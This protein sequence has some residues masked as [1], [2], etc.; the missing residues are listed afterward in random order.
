MSLDPAG[1]TS[2]LDIHLN[3]QKRGDTDLH[4]IKACAFAL[5]KTRL[6]SAAVVAGIGPPEDASFLQMRL[7]TRILFAGLRYA[8]GL[9]G[10]IADISIGKKA[11]NPN[12]EV[13]REAIVRQMKYVKAVLTPTELELFG[14]KPM[15]VDEIIQDFRERFRQGSEGFFRDGRLCVEPWGF[16]MEDVPFEGVRLYYGS[17]DTN[18]P[19]QMGRNMAAKLKGAVFQEFEGETHMTLFENHGDDILKDIME[20]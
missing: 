8:P 6:K 3:S 7:G 12:P 15:F 14:K 11:R 9:V 17:K 19:A 1:P 18:T 2:D 20:H 16:R 5:T 13:L 10:A 4:I